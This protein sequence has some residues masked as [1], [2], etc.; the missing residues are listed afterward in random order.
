MSARRSL[1]LAL[2]LVVAGFAPLPALAAD[3]LVFAAASMR[4][5]LDQ[6]AAA[7]Q[8][9]TGHSVTLSYAGSSAL[10]RQ[11]IAGAPAD[12]FISAAPA[13][14]DVVA[15]EGLLAAGSR[16][17][18]LGNRLV[19][20]GHGAAVGSEDAE[21]GGAE[22]AAEGAAEGGAE[23]LADIGP[24]DAAGVADLSAGYELAARLGDGR[25]AMALVDAVPAGQ[26][27]KAGLQALGLWDGVAAQ[28]AQADNVRAALA[29]VATGEAPMGV[30]YASDALAEP[31]V[32]VLAIF[33]E[34]SHAPITY[35][36]A[37]LTDAAPEAE[38]FLQALQ[39]PAAGAI[40]EAHGFEVRGFEPLERQ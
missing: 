2:P 23:G 6:V 9:E 40:F 10:A 4:G 15:G 32:Q 12:I 11:I 17:D 34:G 38:G 18:L 29:L 39:A 36:A 27:G 20:I 8:A 22:G 3:I 5:A 14:M 7:W 35:P 31:A 30:V 16:V 19:L 21:E 37:L 33:P 1:M 13:W 25:L 28:V 26:Y 24:A